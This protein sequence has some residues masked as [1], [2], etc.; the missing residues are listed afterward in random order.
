[1]N[2]TETGRLRTI[3]IQNGLDER[4]EEARGHLRWSRSYMY[5]YALTKFLQELNILTEVVH[6]DTKA[7]ETQANE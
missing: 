6:N 7:K 3:Y 5:K 4:V 1:M 2:R